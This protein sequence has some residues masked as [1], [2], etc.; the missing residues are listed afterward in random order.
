MNFVQ[1]NTQI[2]FDLNEPR[3]KL[4]LIFRNS[5]LAKTILREDGTVCSDFPM[6]FFPYYQPIYYPRS[7]ESLFLTLR[8]SRYQPN[9]SNPS[10]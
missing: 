1:I 8:T 6:L 4:D 3:R 9:I 10:L 7:P 5:L 2:R